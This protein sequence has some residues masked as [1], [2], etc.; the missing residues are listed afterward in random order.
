MVIGITGNFGTGKST[1]ACMFK[2]LGARL[3]DADKIAHQLLKDK[4]RTYEKVIACFGQGIISAPSGNISRKKLADIVF[5]NPE[6]LKR[7]NSIMH[8]AIVKAIQQKISQSSDSQILVVD[9]ALLIEWVISSA[10]HRHY[11]RIKDLV[12]WIDKLI[13]VTARLQTRALRLKKQGW[14]IN[15]IEKR[16]RFQL[17]DNKKSRFADFVIDNNG[18]RRQTEK[19]A[20]EIWDKISLSAKVSPINH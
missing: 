3:I 15:Q 11:K 1:V 10:Y 2:Q 9:A 8:P 18:S 14:T 16:L 4:G 20:R 12:P 19:Q 17:P 6:A 7:L 13:I 5:N